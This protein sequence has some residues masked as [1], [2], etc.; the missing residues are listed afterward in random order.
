MQDELS[1]NVLGKYKMLGVASKQFCWCVKCKKAALKA[2][3]GEVESGFFIYQYQ[4][5]LQI[6]FF[7]C[8]H[9]RESETSQTAMTVTNKCCLCD[10]GDGLLRKTVGGQF[11]HYTCALM[12][13]KVRILSAAEMKFDISEEE[14]RALEHKKTRSKKAAATSAFSYSTF[15]NQAVQIANKEK[16]FDD[17]SLLALKFDVT[18]KDETLWNLTETRELQEAISTLLDLGQGQKPKKQGKKNKKHS[19]LQQEQPNVTLLYG[20]ESKEVLTTELSVFCKS[21]QS[22]IKLTSEVHKEKFAMNVVLADDP[23]RLHLYCNCWENKDGDNFVACDECHVWYHCGCV[24]VNLDTIT[25]T[26]C[27]FCNKC[28]TLQSLESKS[29]NV[30]LEELSKIKKERLTLS[31]SIILGVISEKAIQ[32]S[33]KLTEIAEF[34]VSFLD[35]SHVINSRLSEVLIGGY[36]IRRTTELL[37][38][39]DPA[40]VYQDGAI[41]NEEFIRLKNTVLASKPVLQLLSGMEDL[42]GYKKFKDLLEK[43]DLALQLYEEL[44]P[45]SI[46][47]PDII[48]VAKRVEMHPE[49]K[50]LAAHRNFITALTVARSKLDMVYS[51]FR[52][53]AAQLD[54]QLAANNVQ[55]VQQAK[56]TNSRIAEYKKDLSEN[57]LATRIVES[58]LGDLG[59][60]EAEKNS[61]IPLK[62]DYFLLLLKRELSS[63]VRA[64]DSEVCRVWQ[65]KRQ[66][67]ED[68]RIIVQKVQKLK[69]ELPQWKDV[70]EL[71]D[72]SAVFATKGEVERILTEAEDSILIMNSAALKKLQDLKFATSRFEKKAGGDHWNSFESA[73]RHIFNMMKIGVLFGDEAMIMVREL[74]LHGQLMKF[75]NHKGNFVLQEVEETLN[76]CRKRFEMDWYEKAKNM[77]DEIKM[78]L[79]KAH[80]AQSNPDLWVDERILEDCLRMFKKLQDYKIV[81]PETLS[82]FSEVCRAIDWMFELAE[83]GGVVRE[84]DRNKNCCLKYAFEST[85]QKILSIEGSILEMI[86][87]RTLSRLEKTYQ[88]AVFKVHPDI[89]RLSE[90]A[91]KKILAKELEEV[92]LSASSSAT[93]TAKLPT[94]HLEDVKIILKRAV[95]L[96][97]DISKSSPQLATLV[98]EWR[99]YREQSL[100]LLHRA[101]TH[102][103]I[104]TSRKEISDI[105]SVTSA[106]FSFTSI[107]GISSDWVSLQH[108]A[109]KLLIFSTKVHKILHFSSSGTSHE[110]DHESNMDI[111]TFHNKLETGELQALDELV[112]RVTEQLQTNVETNSLLPHTQAVGMLLHG[113]T[114]QQK[115]RDMCEDF[116][117]KVSSC[118]QL[119]SQL[120]DFQTKFDQ[121]MLQMSELKSQKQP[122]TVQTIIELNQQKGTVTDAVHLLKEFE[123]ANI[124]A[125]DSQRTSLTR[126][127]EDCRRGEEEGLTIAQNYLSVVVT[128][129]KDTPIAVHAAPLPEVCW[130]EINKVKMA[131]FD[132]DWTRYVRKVE[133]SVLTSDTV[134]ERLQTISCIN[135]IFKAVCES[136]SLGRW[137]KVRDSVKE[138][139]KAFPGVATTLRPIWK[140]FEEQYFLLEKISK[141]LDLDVI[142]LEE[143]KNLISL[144]KQTKV[145]CLGEVNFAELVEDLEQVFE[146]CHAA[147]KATPTQKVTIDVMKKARTSLDE[148]Q[149]EIK[150]EETQHI[151]DSIEAHRE[152]HKMMEIAQKEG[153]LSNGILSDFATEIY[154]N[155]P[156]YSKE[157]EDYISQRNASLKAYEQAEQAIKAVD[158]PG[159]DDNYLAHEPK[160]L[161]FSIGWA[162]RSYKLLLFIWA[163]KLYDCREKKLKLNMLTLEFMHQEALDWYERCKNF[164]PH[165]MEVMFSM[166][167]GKIDFL[168]DLIRTSDSFLETISKVHTEAEF[169]SLKS[170]FSET[171]RV[172]LDNLLIDMKMSLRSASKIDHKAPRRLWISD[173]FREVVKNGPTSKSELNLKSEFSKLDEFFDK[174][175]QQDRR[176]L[177]PR[178]IGLTKGHH[179]FPWREIHLVLEGPITSR[180]E[181][182]LG[183]RKLLGSKGPSNTV[184][185]NKDRFPNRRYDEPQI[186][187]SLSNLGVQEVINVDRPGLSGRIGGK[188]DSSSNYVNSQA[189]R[190][191]TLMQA[192]PEVVDEPTRNG[193]RQVFLR[194][195]E[196]N[197]V[198]N[199]GTKSNESKMAETSREL[200]ARIFSSSKTT[201]EYTQKYNAIKNA[202][203]TLQSHRGLTRV[204]ISK[205]FEM[206]FLRSLNIKLPQELAK[207]DREAL[208]KQSADSQII[209]ASIGSGGYNP[210]SEFEPTFDSLLSRKK[211][212]TNKFDNTS[213]ILKT[214]KQKLLE[215]Q[216]RQEEVIP[217][218]K[219]NL[220]EDLLNM[221]TAEMFDANKFGPALEPE[222]EKLIN[223]PKKYN[224][225]SGLK[226]LVS[227]EK[228]TVKAEPKSRKSSPSAR[229]DD[230]DSKGKRKRSRERK[231]DKKSKKDKKHREEN[232][233]FSVDSDQDAFKPSIEID[234]K[235][236]GPF[237]QDWLKLNY[238]RGRIKVFGNEESKKTNTELLS[239]NVQLN[240]TDPSAIIK[241]FPD[242][243]K[244]LTL[245]FGKYERDLSEIEPVYNS[246]HRKYDQWLQNPVKSAKI[247][248]ITVIGGW[249]TFESKYEERITPLIEYLSKNPKSITCAINNTSSG[250]FFATLGKNLDSQTLGNL[251]IKAIYNSGQTIQVDNLIVFFL[252]FSKHKDIS[253]SNRLAPHLVQSF[254]AGLENTFRVESK[255]NPSQHEDSDKFQ[256]VV[257]HFRNLKPEDLKET[258]KSLDE[259][260]EIKARAVQIIQ[261]SLP[262]FRD[263]L[264]ELG[265]ITAT[266]P[267]PLPTP[268]I[269]NHP[270]PMI[271]APPMMMY[272]P[273]MP[274]ANMSNPMPTAGPQPG[275]PPSGTGMPM[276][277]MPPMQYPFYPGPPKGNFPMYPPMMNPMPPGVPPRPPGNP[278]GMMPGN[279]P[280][281]YRFMGYPPMHHGPGLPNSPHGMPGMLAPGYPM[282]PPPGAPLLPGNMGPK[283]TDQPN[284]SGG[285][286]S[287]SP[288]P[289][290]GHMGPP[291]M[292]GNPY[293]LPPGARPPFLPPGYPAYPPGGAGIPPLQPMP[294]K[295]DQP[296]GQPQIQPEGSILSTPNPGQ[297]VQP[298]PQNEHIPANPFQLPANPQQQLPQ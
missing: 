74:Q 171:E 241:R 9:C 7:K 20:I 298:S 5:G 117:K 134:V 203:H 218:K 213:T 97:T 106:L 48:S 214:Q 192:E 165:D 204:A 126:W 37:N 92:G 22:P 109:S 295:Q 161:K 50:T 108:I 138:T 202:L 178:F 95:C 186:V 72:P 144:C 23:S 271:S 269:E 67:F 257:E 292:G 225:V 2:C 200:E 290:P 251:G 242:I 222:K 45:R 210:L 110:M 182:I 32:D 76:Q 14:L 189:M 289:G 6:C 133:S 80:E 261:T 184:S 215:Q 28:R 240:T 90:K 82:K 107:F 25:N 277:P 168:E 151:Y 229:E 284:S 293:F 162:L 139:M 276:G 272:P 125:E 288:F 268:I 54:V 167:V 164:L 19:Q 230:D 59:V 83:H 232:P 16:E 112:M 287:P 231:K 197:I 226:A 243:E 130:M 191:L 113:H 57:G 279:P 280:P 150:H 96:D 129:A 36:L 4:S 264:I 46:R 123:R 40:R 24:G 49:L 195:L 142:S 12:N 132:K 249:M 176:N 68:S 78:I 183:K 207:M 198:M 99:T 43:F 282:Y 21:A 33:T 180:E 259:D 141:I 201:S 173:R 35:L 246:E 31:E 297:G 81:L 116:H 58:M 177:E 260:V 235:T 174:L 122:I 220:L 143:A 47:I 1:P 30:T 274:V 75:C 128:P 291:F 65:E 55:G 196:A 124:A 41:L 157:M 10:E 239:F 63:V 187:G 175:A 38:T 156:I 234:P 44:K 111:E 253:D 34:D 221:S 152:L 283:P 77:I 105:Q 169:D 69:T 56:L 194:E 87:V 18:Q 27:F 163:R 254:H 91:I 8:D 281:P 42:P 247:P 206:S 275:F 250:V 115:W 103:M 66:L 255:N 160:I 188:S 154:A 102:N 205:D 159:S 266:A 179:N 147:K 145:A 101:G 135:R 39:L 119:S 149:L 86:N 88:Q 93:L 79:S 233:D 121:F 244:T 262:Q 70:A 131:T 217:E 170:K 51:D 263:V 296:S 224:F 211:T 185:G 256:E 278:P 208:E 52:T 172:D 3:I 190:N 17:V 118:A 89:K 267:G 146:D 29:K 252:K 285:P 248:E 223:Q 137:S 98:S 228:V 64:G 155:L 286:V 219:K 153:L 212:A 237:G 273:N 270:G 11:V 104:P 94:V 140:P 209:G 166:I 26:S 61:E 114:A 294:V 84:T 148:C 258:L 181:M 216:Q 227:K 13:P 245:T 60:V 265:L 127:I 73:K 62:L 100:A 236:L 71:S 120:T 199:N 193:T 15:R 136:A 238:T 53:F 85:L 158:Q